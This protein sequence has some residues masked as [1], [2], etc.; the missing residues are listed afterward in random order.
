VAFDRAAWLAL[1]D[2]AEAKALSDRLDAQ[3]PESARSGLFGTNWDSPEQVKATFRALGVTLDS[4]DDEHLAAVNPLAEALRDYR[5]VQKRGTTYGRAWLQHVS[6]DGRV[7]AGWRQIGADSGRM[8]CRDPNLQNLPRDPRYRKCF[9]AS[10]GRVLVK[11]D[12]SQV[13]LRIAAKIAGDER[14]VEATGGAMTCTS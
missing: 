9:V 10:P 7:Y 12:Y 13:E 3:V 8:A 11:A 6:P 5:A 2:E 4:T 14:M 1:A